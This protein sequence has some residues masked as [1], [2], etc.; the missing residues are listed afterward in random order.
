MKS[1]L[2]NYTACKWENYR[3]GE[4]TALALSPFPELHKGGKEE[5]KLSRR[6]EEAMVRS[7][8]PRRDGHRRAQWVL[9]P[10]SL[11]LSLPLTSS[12]QVQELW[13]SPLPHPSGSSCC[14]FKTV[15]V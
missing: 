7:G 15:C 9:K 10:A 4:C 13:F 6:G 1:K 12:L 11:L 2:L 8:R 14:D 5:T 3:L